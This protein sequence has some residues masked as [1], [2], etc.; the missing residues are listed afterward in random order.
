MKVIGSLKKRV[1]TNLSKACAQINQK[2]EIGRV[3]EG[4]KSHLSFL[5]NA[6]QRGAE[7]RRKTT[8]GSLKALKMME[9]IS[10][11]SRKV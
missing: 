11:S 7:G 4:E 3:Q 10:R 9:V 5:L 8:E 6:F 1:A 2:V